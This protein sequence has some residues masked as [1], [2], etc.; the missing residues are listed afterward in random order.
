MGGCIPAT[1][2]QVAWGSIP[3]PP[4]ILPACKENELAIVSD[5]SSALPLALCLPRLLQPKRNPCPG[6]FSLLNGP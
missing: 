5:V 4:S 2:A 1:L 6:L 3:S